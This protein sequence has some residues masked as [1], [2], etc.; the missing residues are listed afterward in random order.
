MLVVIA[1]ANYVGANVGTNVH[2]GANV[3][4]AL[5]FALTNVGCWC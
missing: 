2:V 1:S 3:G 4:V 5:V